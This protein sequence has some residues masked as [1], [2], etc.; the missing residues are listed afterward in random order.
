[1]WQ[2]CPICNGTGVS[3]ISGSYSSIP[4]CPTCNGARIISEIN[5]LPPASIPTPSIESSS[6]INKMNPFVGDF[7]DANMESQDEYFGKK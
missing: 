7:R 6:T 4:T 2:K 3:P 1:M 5:G